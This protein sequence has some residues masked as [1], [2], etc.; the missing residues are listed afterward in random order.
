M[1]MSMLY[2]MIE[3]RNTASREQQRQVNWRE[4]NAASTIKVSGRKL[5]CVVRCGGSET[6][7]GTLFCQ[8]IHYGT[9]Y[10]STR[11]R[12]GYLPEPNGQPVI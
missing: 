6:C 5:S 9:G 7:V 12:G 10:S 2:E 1:K 4:Y 11:Q 8:R 3:E